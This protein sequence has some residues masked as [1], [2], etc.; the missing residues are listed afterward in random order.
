MKEPNPQFAQG[1]LLLS[2]PALVLALLWR[3]LAASP[4]LS[5]RALGA[6]LGLQ[7]QQG[8]P[9]RRPRPC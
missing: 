9:Q 4:A 3:G 5:A 6:E 2:W 1:P 8:A 7:P